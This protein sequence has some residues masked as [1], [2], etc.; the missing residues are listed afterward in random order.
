[1]IAALA[2]NRNR[3][4]RREREDL[5][6]NGSRVGNCLYLHQLFVCHQNFPDFADYQ[7]R[8]VKTF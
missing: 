1:M 3:S 8:Y 6:V 7:N 4:G 5:E 2:R